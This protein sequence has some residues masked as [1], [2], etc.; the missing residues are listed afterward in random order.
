MRYQVVLITDAIGSTPTILH[1]DSP[2]LV[3]SPGVRF[4][5][6][7]ETDDHG[8]AIAVAQLLKKKC[9]DE[10]PNPAVDWDAIEAMASDRVYRVAGVFGRAGAG[11]RPT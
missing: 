6:V 2:P 4:R 9:R 1:D 11:S 10:P 8:E 3:G 7:A 5:L